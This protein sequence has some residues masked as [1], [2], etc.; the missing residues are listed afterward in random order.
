MSVVVVVVWKG[1]C[2]VAVLAAMGRVVRRRRSH[3]VAD[4]VTFRS[5]GFQPLSFSSLSAVDVGLLNGHR[6]HPQERGEAEEEG[7]EG[8]EGETEKQRQDAIAG[9]RDKRAVPRLSCVRDRRRVTNCVIVKAGRRWG[10]ACG[11]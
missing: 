6:H 9:G 1:I 5:L 2:V 4:N 11:S 7:E 8:E 3:A 10:V